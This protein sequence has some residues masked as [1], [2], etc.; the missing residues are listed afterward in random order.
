MQPDEGS[1]Y[2]PSADAKSG[3]VTGVSAGDG[4]HDAAGAI[5]VAADVV[6]VAAVGELRVRLAAWVADLAPDPDGWE[7]VQQWHQLDDPWSDFRR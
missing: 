7:G 5:L 1:L 3:A 4:G 2:H 6:A